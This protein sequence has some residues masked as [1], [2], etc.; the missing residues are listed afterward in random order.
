MLKFN[1]NNICCY[2][3]ALLNKI[4]KNITL[5]QNQLLNIHKKFII[6][7]EQDDQHFDRKVLLAV[8]IISNFL[9]P[10]MGAAVNV[11]LP[12]IAEELNLTAIGQA[13]ITTAYLLTAVIFL[14]PFGKIGDMFGRKKIFLWGNVLFMLSTFLCAFAVSDAML[15]ASRLIQGIGGAMIAGTSMAI[16]ML[17]FPL[18]Q[19]GKIIGYNIASVYAGLAFAPIIG[20]FLTQ[21]LGWR[22]LFFV[23]GFFGILISLSIF[24]KI[25]AEWVDKTN[26]KFDFMGSIILAISI[27]SLMVGFSKLPNFSHVVLTLIGIIGLVGFGWF[28]SK[29]KNPVL[30]IELFTHNRNFA[31]A[32]LTALIN[33]AATFAVTFVVSLYLQYAKG[34]SPRDAGAMLVAQPFTMSLVSTIA[35]RLSDKRDPHILASI[36]M[37]IIVVGLFLLS[38]LQQA[39]S[40]YYII[41]SLLILGVGF[42]LFSSPNTNTAMST[43]D[44]KFYGIASATLGTMRSMG[45]M[46]SMAIA[47]LASYLFV[48][49]NKITTTNLPEYLQSVQVVFIIFSV[50][51]FIGVFTSLMGFKKSS[52]I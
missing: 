50:L 9:T 17:A 35:G 11:A 4:T 8:T 20:G 46:F 23:S 49:D 15:I 2:I 18:E 14:V 1:T 40:N 52:T 10:M 41:G 7:M 3:A 6:H 47:T 5:L 36:G 24:F 26:E 34:L 25:K 16:I 51:C 13:W 22:S 19:R 39:T 48:G 44:R 43:V 38:F 42:G 31:F 45:M 33:Y 21:Y 30:N 28:E 29:I 32:N 37:S 12:K 27:V